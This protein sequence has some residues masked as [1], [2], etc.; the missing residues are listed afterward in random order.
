MMMMMCVWLVCGIAWCSQHP[1]WSK[2]SVSLLLAYN[3]REFHGNVANLRDLNREQT[4]DGVLEK[5][6]YHAGCILPSNYGR[7]D[8]KSWQ[9]SSRTDK[10]V[11]STFTWVHSRI[12]VDPSSLAHEPMGDTMCSAINAH[13]PESVRVFAVMRVP[14]SFDPRTACI[15]RMYE[16]LLPARVLAKPI[17]ESMPKLKSALS[18]MEGYKPFHNFT[19]RSLYRPPANAVTRKR[20]QPDHHSDTKGT[21]TDEAADGDVQAE[22]DEH[23]A[24]SDEGDTIDGHIEMNHQGQPSDDHNRHTQRE[25]TRV[26]AHDHNGPVRGAVEPGSKTRNWFASWVA[27]ADPNDLIGHSHFRKVF[28]FTCGQPRRA[29]GARSEPVEHSLDE[30]TIS[31]PEIGEVYLPITV[32]GNS[33]MLHQIRRMVGTAVAVA[34]GHI[35]MDA[36]EASMSRPARMLTPRAPAQ[37]LLLTGAEFRTFK[38]PPQKEEGQMYEPPQ[39]LEVADD[40]LEE[41]HRFKEQVIVPG[42]L[43]VLSDQHWD[44]W[45]S[46]LSGFGSE[47]ALTQRQE[48]VD[49][50]MEY[51]ATKP[52]HVKTKEE[53]EKRNRVMQ[54]NK[55]NVQ[56]VVG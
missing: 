45:T 2:K 24:S 35:S 43:P 21:E 26:T 9:H 39:K 40:V 8:T 16:Y 51:K 49:R 11:S 46:K 37:A 3:G 13:L 53:E 29:N 7:L 19:K 25:C 10:G 31:D 12:L 15:S 27:Q 56:G 38:V 41:L 23:N 52:E 28:R 22:S 54:A 17:S 1:H 6:M 4:V 20:S 48:L 47:Q 33:F 5:A 55:H 42:M 14:K 34:N 44:D 50:Y 36:L 18:A 30:C 32:H